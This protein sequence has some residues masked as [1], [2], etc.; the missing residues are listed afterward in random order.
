MYGFK[1]DKHWNW[2]GGLSFQ[3]YPLEFNKK[4]EYIRNKFNRICQLCHQPEGK[5]KL[6]VHHIDY[7][8]QNANE[9]NLIPLCIACHM[10]TNFNRSYWMEFFMSRSEGVNV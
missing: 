1:L 6:D 5:R 3:R 10:K 8:K 9:L 2:R 7:D 4:R